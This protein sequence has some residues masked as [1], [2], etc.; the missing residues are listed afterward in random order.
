MQAQKPQCIKDT[1]C[2][3]VAIKKKNDKYNI[4]VS[5]PDTS[6]SIQSVGF[7]ADNS[8]TKY[9][10]D[11]AQVERSVTGENTFLIMNV[12]EGFLNSIIKANNSEILITTNKGYINGVIKANN[13][14]SGLFKGINNFLD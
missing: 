1:V 6:M 13:M 9:E 5:I 14:E 12:D 11:S 10:V 4:F 2:P 7:K 3:E 8:I